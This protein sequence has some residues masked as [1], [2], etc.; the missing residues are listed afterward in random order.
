MVEGAPSTTIS[1]VAIVISY[2]EARGIHGHATQGK[3]ERI[4]IDCDSDFIPLA[5]NSSVNLGWLGAP[6]ILCHLVCMYM[7][8][9]GHC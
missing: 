4:W 9:W 8:L 2:G 7:Y 6:L 3:L 1:G 5:Y